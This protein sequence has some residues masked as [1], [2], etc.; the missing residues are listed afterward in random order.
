MNKLFTLKKSIVTFGLLLLSAYIILWVSQLFDIDNSCYD[1]SIPWPKRV[2]GL[3][4]NELCTCLGIPI[5]IDETPSD[6]G[7]HPGCVG[8]KIT[9][10]VLTENGDLFDGG[11][12]VDKKC[13][14]GTVEYDHSIN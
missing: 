1:G 3:V 11:T 14:E 4:E 6:G 13:D 10:C 9:S 7:I 5:T 8:V 12:V 2:D